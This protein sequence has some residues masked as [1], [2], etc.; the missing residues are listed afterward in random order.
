MS[1]EKK[2]KLTGKQKL[3]V[4]A[5]S[6]GMAG[7]IAVSGYHMFNKNSATPTDEPDT[8]IVGEE[9][10]VPESP[11]DGFVEIDDDDRETLADDTLNKAIDEVYELA[12]EGNWVDIMTNIDRYDQEYNLDT[13][14]AGEELR[15]LFTDAN[16]L[17][18]LTSMGDTT[19]AL[20]ASLLSLPELNNPEMFV[21]GLY[22]LPRNVMLE[23][24]YDLLALAPT[25]RGHVELVEYQYI[26]VSNEDGAKNTD[27]ENDS[28]IEHYF[29]G[30]LEDDFVEGFHRFDV[31]NYNIE[32]YVYVAEHAGGRFELVGFYSD[33]PNPANTT[34]S[35]SHYRNFNQDVEKG[36][37]ELM[38]EAQEKYD[39]ENN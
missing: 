24:S 2:G 6:V 31:M 14:G 19:D 9:S 3:L 11:D 30:G 22:Y 8:A 37:E 16:V 1:D 23:M 13:E 35:V 39:A 5:L 27:I 25:Q 15:S 21:L 10:D 38:R 18:R 7:V 36:V 33:D 17:T 26:P 32:E 4:G 20:D 28:V 12:Y 29:A 34:K